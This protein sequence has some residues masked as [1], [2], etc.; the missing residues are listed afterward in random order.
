MKRNLTIDII[1]I[2]GILF[3]MI[4]LIYIFIIFKSDAGQCYQDPLVYGVSKLGEANNA[5]LVLKGYFLRDGS[6]LV[7]VTKHNV[8][9]EANP[10]GSLSSPSSKLNVSIFRFTNETN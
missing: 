7:I 5:D 6:P 3:S 8:T 1:I 4:L 9:M 2:S 10:S